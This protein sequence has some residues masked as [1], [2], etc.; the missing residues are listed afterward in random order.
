ML[1]LG[2]TRIMHGGDQV[3]DRDRGLIGGDEG[4]DM[5]QRQ[6]RDGH[7]GDED[8]QRGREDDQRQPALLGGRR[9]DREEGAPVPHTDRTPDPRYFGRQ[10]LKKI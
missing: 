4:I 9:Q 1:I 8:R 10:M 2:N 7:R 6:R 3:V 5:R